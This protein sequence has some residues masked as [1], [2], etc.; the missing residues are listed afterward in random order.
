MINFKTIFLILLLIN[1]CNYTSTKDEQNNNIDLK[2]YRI[3]IR[4]EDMYTT[5]FYSIECNDFETIFKSY[6]IKVLNQIEMNMF[7]HHFN[8]TIKNDLKSKD[9]NTRIRLLGFSKNNSN[10]L[11]LCFDLAK[12]KYGADVYKISDEFKEFLLKL[13]ETKDGG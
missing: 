10:I 13:T 9:I 12:M 8:E 1:S 5:T 2:L 7:S 6:S 4:Y 3:E 11:N